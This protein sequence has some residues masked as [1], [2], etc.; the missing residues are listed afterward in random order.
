MNWKAKSRLMADTEL[1]LTN[2]F[3]NI[4]IIALKRSS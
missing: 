4:N 1:R 3:N 2:F